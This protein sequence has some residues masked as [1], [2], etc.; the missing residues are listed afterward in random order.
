MFSINY[1]ICLHLKRYLTSQLPLHK[2]PNPHPPSPPSPLPPWGCSSTHPPSCTPPLHQ[3]SYARASNL[4]RIKGLPC[5]CCQAR[6]SSATYVSGV[7]DPSLCTPWLVVLSLGELGGPDS[8]CCS[9]YILLCSSIPSAA[10]L[11][12][13]WTQSDGWLQASTSALVSCLPGLPRRFLSTKV[14]PLNHS[15]SV[16]F[17]IHRQDGSPDG[18]SFSLCSI[19]LSLFLLWTASFLC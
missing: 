18:T 10:P 9:S 19:F 15:S 12:G 2:P 3:S 4:H 5:H 1:S 17:G 16:R 6:P 13:P 14:W 8:L 7:M 11:R